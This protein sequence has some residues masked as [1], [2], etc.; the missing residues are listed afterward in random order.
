MAAPSSKYKLGQIK[1]SLVLTF[2][3]KIFRYW[4]I[5]CV[6][7]VTCSLFSTLTL[8]KNSFRN[9]IE[10]SNN[11]DPDHGLHSVSPDLDPNCFHLGYQQMTKV[12]ARKEKV[13]SSH[14]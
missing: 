14:G 2:L 10:M 7:V 13:R 4:V 11:L 6:F 3:K 5:V 9:S 12:A 8:S 1:E